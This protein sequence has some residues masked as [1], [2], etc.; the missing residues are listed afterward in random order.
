MVFFSGSVEGALRAESPSIFLDKS[1]RSKET[2]LAGY[3]EGL[4]KSIRV[5]IL[6]Q[7]CF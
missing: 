6:K 1:G 4:L 7:L 5:Y 2:L 3:V